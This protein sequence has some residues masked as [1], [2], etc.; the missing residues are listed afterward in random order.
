MLTHLTGEIKESEVLHPVVVVDKLSLVRLSAIEVE[1][2]RHLLLDSFLVM[3][4]S[5]RVEKITLLALARRVANH[6]RGTTNEQIR[7][8]A[9]TLQVAQHH[10]TTKVTDV[11]R[12]CSRVCSEIGR[13]HVGVEVFLST[14]HHL[15]QHTT[16]FQFFNK[17]FCHRMSFFYI[18]YNNVLYMGP[19]TLSELT[20]RGRNPNRPTDCILIFAR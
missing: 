1:E 15:R 10:D 3:I 4:E 13:H 2:L 5:L 20:A 16:P 14:W 19:E 8:M 12:V 6:T 18:L 17:V 9:T 11:Q 7:L